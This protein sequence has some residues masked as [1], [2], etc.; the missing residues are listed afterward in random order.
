MKKIKRLALFL[1]FA[2]SVFASNNFKI[3][4]IEKMP[5][6]KLAVD[7]SV[8]IDRGQFPT[9]Q[10]LVNIAKTTL[11]DNMGYKRYFFN[12]YLPDMEPGH[13]AYGVII[14]ENKKVT[15]LKINYIN[16][17]GTKYEKDLKVDNDGNYYL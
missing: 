10:D 5:Y 2:T 1:L 9:L 13:G 17:I 6:E 16:L 4:N 14:F 3:L 7:Y 11:K 12:Y 15:E 8:M